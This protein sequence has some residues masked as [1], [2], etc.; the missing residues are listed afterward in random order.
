MAFRRT[1]AVGLGVACA[2]GLGACGDES[3]SEPPP[4]EERADRTGSLP[5]GWTRVVNRRAGFSLGIPPGWTARGARG[6]TLVRSG[7]R[8]LAVSIAAD[9]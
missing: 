4:P 7:D 6:A 5:A 3:P 1:I 2:A 9:R 8:L